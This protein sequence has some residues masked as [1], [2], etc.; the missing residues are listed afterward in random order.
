MGKLVSWSRAIEVGT[1][2]RKRKNALLD[3]MSAMEERYFAE[4]IVSTEFM[5]LKK[6]ENE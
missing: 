3:L 2:T 1:E 5:S 4:A 6:R